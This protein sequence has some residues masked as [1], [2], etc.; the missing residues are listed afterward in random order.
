MSRT[1]GA[2]DPDQLFLDNIIA[3]GSDVV[4]S[5]NLAKGH[6]DDPDTLYQVLKMESA[7]LII[8]KRAREYRERLL[9][10]KRQANKPNS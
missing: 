6:T 10:L 8:Q 2:D 3:L 4:S 9:A 7:A 5:A 1:A